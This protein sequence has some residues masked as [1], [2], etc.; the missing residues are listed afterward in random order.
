MLPAS[1]GACALLELEED[2]AVR[3]GLA[4]HFLLVVG[5]FV[6]AEV[7]FGQFG[8]VRQRRDVADLVLPKVQR[9]QASHPRQGREVAD[10]IAGKEQSS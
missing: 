4:E 1:G 2:W 8:Q 9:G 10:V 6:G 5:D 3:Q 7:Q